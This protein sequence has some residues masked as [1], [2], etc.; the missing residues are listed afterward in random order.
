MAA[1]SRRI[2][3]TDREIDRLL[4]ALYDL[5]DEKIRIVEKATAR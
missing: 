4:Y 5:T 3:A 1:V 2:D